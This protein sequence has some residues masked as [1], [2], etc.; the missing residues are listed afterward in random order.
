MS[1]VVPVAAL[2]AVCAAVVAVGAHDGRARAAGFAVAL[3]AS[4]G[5][6]DPGPA[7]LPLL[8]RVIAGLLAGELSWLLLRTQAASAGGPEREAAPLGLA[9][10]AALA[11]AAFVGGVAAAMAGP[12][13]G[14]AAGVNQWSG[15]IAVG[16]GL[17][18]VAVGLPALLGG[19]GSDDVAGVDRAIAA[20]LV[21]V[22]AWAV[23]GAIIGPP[24]DVESLLLGAVT[25][26]AVTV[27]A[28]TD[29]G[30]AADAEPA[31][32]RRGWTIPSRAMRG[33]RRPPDAHPLPASSAGAETRSTR[34]G[35]RP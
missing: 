3:A 26:L 14:I 16:A 17:A 6:S 2:A 4:A 13:L 9:G 21:L 33:R 31:P 12:G 25:V 19:S 35:R 34:S 23:R 20:T 10:L 7:P 27:V 29:P 30:A 1:P 24:A 8:G 18:M 11:L 28:I 22:G 15:A 32:T 5:L